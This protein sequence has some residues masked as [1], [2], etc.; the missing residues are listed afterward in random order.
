MRLRLN[1]ND[2]IDKEYSDT[3]GSM[4]K[5]RQR[6]NFSEEQKKEYLQKQRDYSRLYR[7]RKRKE[8]I[9]KMKENPNESYTLKQLR[10]QSYE[11]KMNTEKQ[12]F[13]KLKD[14]VQEALNKDMKNLVDFEEFYAK[15]V[16]KLVERATGEISE[17]TTMNYVADRLVSIASLEQRQKYQ[18]KI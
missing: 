7:E 11:S 1:D 14:M 18:I 17:E 2:E 6:D 12:L 16:S 10:Q 5:R 4:I 8:L 9:Q 15:S 3:Y 13:D